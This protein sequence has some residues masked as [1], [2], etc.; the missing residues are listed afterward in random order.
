MSS[1]GFAEAG[2][3]ADAGEPG[4]TLG[5]PLGAA[6]IGVIRPSSAPSTGVGAGLRPIGRGGATATDLAPGPTGAATARGWALGALGAPAPPDGLAP[7]RLTLGPD[8]EFTRASAPFEGDV[9]AGFAAD[10]GPCAAP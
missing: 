9:T 7:F 10:K 8:A 3:A 4:A 2:A 1:R 5:A 6:S